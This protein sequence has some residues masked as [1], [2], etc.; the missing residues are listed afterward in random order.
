[1]F[2]RLKELKGYTIQATDGEIGK[3]D[4]FYFDDNEWTIRYAVVDT[5]GWLSGR[6]VLLTPDVLGRPIKNGKIY[7]VNLTRQ[8][9]KDS[10]NINTER[11]VS[12]QEEESLFGY[13]NWPPYW[14]EGMGPA[15]P[16]GNPAIPAVPVT[17]T[18]N[19]G[20]NRTDSG[21]NEMDVLPE[22]QRY[23]PFLRSFNE[24]AGYHINAEDGHAGKVED[25]IV[26]DEK[27]NILYMIVEPGG[28]FSSKRVLLAP[29]WVQKVSLEDKRLDVALKADTIKNSPDF[30]PTLPLDADFQTQVN[31]HYGR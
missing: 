2:E 23:N 5:G 12:R 24:V 15:I 11:P 31:T 13:Y 20:I 30:D 14:P 19:P 8:Q 28:L 26:E 17:G 1:M 3:I 16:T 4:D 6:K 21:V 22:E 29:S 18:M 25:F 9:V 7:P 27:W 10:P